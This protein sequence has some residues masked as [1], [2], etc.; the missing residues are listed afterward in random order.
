MGYPIQ[1]TTVIDFSTGAQFGY[2]LI[3]DD[4]VN[5]ILGKNILAD[6]AS[7]IVDVSDQVGKINITGGY[8]LF[9]DQFQAGTATVRIYDQNGD[10]NP[11]SVTSPYYPNLVPLRKIRISATFAGQTYYLHSGYITAYNY[12]F[13]TDQSIGYVE[14][15]SVDGFRLMQLANVT[16]LAGTYSG[17]D[18]GSRINAILDDI[19]WPPS[20]R[21]IMTGGSETLCQADPA[22]TRTALQAIKNVEFT[23][24]GAFYMN[25]EGDAVFRSRA[26]ISGTSGANPTYFNNNGTTGINYS[27]ITFALDDKLIINDALITNIGGAV[28]EA[29]VQSSIDKYFQHSISQNNLVGLTDSDAFNIALNYVATR[30]DTSLRIDNIT[31]NLS[32]LD[33]A[34]GITAALALDYFN[35][36]DITNYGVDGTVTHKVLQCMGMNYDITPNAFLTTFTSSEPIVGSFIL[37]STTYGIIGDP[38]GYSILGY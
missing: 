34:A 7:Q 20:L 6:A 11:Q 19:G 2:P 32:T 16:T 22:T 5:G 26:Y 8:N 35:T 38:A 1:V 18:T 21:Q 23:E 36:M 15:T 24:Q 10:W 28:Q 14:I 25:G 33:Y 17:Q 30:A 3:L 29:Y 12:T 13:P 37:D 27:N 31:L 4:P 9:Q